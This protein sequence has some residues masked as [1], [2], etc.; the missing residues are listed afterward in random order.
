[1]VVNGENRGRVRTS[2]LLTADGPVLGRFLVFWVTLGEVASLHC[3]TSVSPNQ[4]DAGPSSAGIQI[5]IDQLEL[6]VSCG[7]LKSV[8]RRQWG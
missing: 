6:C 2:V 4:R 5:K 7:W 3:P 1:M 8:S